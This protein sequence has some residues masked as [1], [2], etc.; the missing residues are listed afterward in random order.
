ML[1]IVNS[2]IRKFRI[3]VNQIIAN[4]DNTIEDVTNEAYI[5]VDENLSK[6][7]KNERVFIN[8]LKT[9]CLKFNKYGKRIES[10]DRW[11]VFNSREEDMT[12]TISTSYS[13]NEDMLCLKL[14]IKDVVGEENYN[15][16]LD[17]FSYPKAYMS[18]KYKISE[19][20]INK[21]AKKLI[22]KLRR[23]LCQT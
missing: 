12:N 16:L 13:I 22:D 20:T 5:V 15:F 6:I 7:M 19:P 23:E 8:E 21:R 11:E 17:Y 4:S 10:K 14:D 1:D 2:L 18:L 9:R 3:N